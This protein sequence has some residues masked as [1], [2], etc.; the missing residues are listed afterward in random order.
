MPTINTY[1]GEVPYDAGFTAGEVERKQRQ[2]EEAY[3]MAQM[4]RQR[5][6]D[7][8]RQE[9]QKLQIMNEQQEKARQQRNWEMKLLAEQK[10]H[11]DLMRLREME[12]NRKRKRDQISA[13]E[14][15]APNISFAQQRDMYTDIARA[16]GEG[17]ITPKNWQDTRATMANYTPEEMLVRM[18]EIVSRETN[19]DDGNGLMDFL[20]NAAKKVY[21]LATAPL[22]IAFGKSDV[23][24]ALPDATAQRSASPEKRQDTSNRQ[25][26]M[27]KAV[28]EIG[29][30]AEDVLDT[31]SKKTVAQKKA[32]MQKG[33]KFRKAARRLEYYTRLLN[34]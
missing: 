4:Q 32:Y 31:W 21:G 18:D 34:D 17:E 2:R 16:V 25:S 29:E 1:G 15:D 10:R 28:Q 12:L 13:M 8:M 7:Q 14:S 22:R 20:G 11:D 19:E 5:E 9:M 33:P 23:A 3:R 27:A 24:E 30:N 6:R 26:V